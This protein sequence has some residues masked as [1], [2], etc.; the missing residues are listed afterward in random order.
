M[1]PLV[2]VAYSNDMLFIQYLYILQCP[3]TFGMGRTVCFTS[4]TDIVYYQKTC[5]PLFGTVKESHKFPFAMS[6]II[7]CQQTCHFNNL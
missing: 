1:Q 5:T 4:Y 3:C 2:H 6:F 7:I